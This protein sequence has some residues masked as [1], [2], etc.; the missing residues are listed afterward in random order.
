MNNF[1][2]KEAVRLFCKSKINVITS[3]APTCT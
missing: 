3:I 1:T 2:I